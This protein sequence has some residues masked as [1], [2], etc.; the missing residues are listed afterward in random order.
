MKDD[1]NG[2]RVPVDHYLL[3]AGMPLMLR[4]VIAVA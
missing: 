2:Y 4:S 1:N 3:A